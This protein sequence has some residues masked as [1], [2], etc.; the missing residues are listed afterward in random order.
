MIGVNDMTNTEIRENLK[1][2]F[3][4]L[5]NLEIKGVVNADLVTAAAQIIKHLDNEFMERAV[6]KTVKKEDEV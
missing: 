3:F 2:V 1:K 5:N 6:S 4:F